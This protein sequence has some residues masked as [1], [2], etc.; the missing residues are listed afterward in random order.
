[1]LELQGPPYP[2]QGGSADVVRVRCDQCGD[3]T[4][5][6]LDDDGVCPAYNGW[7]RI[8]ALYVECRK[9]K[10]YENVWLPAVTRLY[11]RG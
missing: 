5:W 1:M 9:C 4:G 10:T 8:T 2:D 11:F 6:F 3:V 7:G